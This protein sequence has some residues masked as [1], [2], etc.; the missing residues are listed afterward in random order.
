MKDFRWC[1]FNQL[2]LHKR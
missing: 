1:P 2:S